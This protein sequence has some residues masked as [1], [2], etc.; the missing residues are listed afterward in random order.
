MIQTLTATAIC[1]L[2]SAGLAISALLAAQTGTALADKESAPGQMRKLGP[3]LE[4]VANQSAAPALEGLAARSAPQNEMGMAGPNND[5]KVADVSSD[6]YVTID[7]VASGSADRS[8]PRP[9]LHA[10]QPC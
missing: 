9:R 2:L 10:V 4:Y 6:G 3:A 8:V 7:A 5:L 1:F